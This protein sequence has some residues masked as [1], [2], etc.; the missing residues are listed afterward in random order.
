MFSR[1]REKGA[2]GKNGLRNVC[3]KTAQANITEIFMYFWLNY[4]NKNNHVE[5][6]RIP[7]AV[8]NNGH[9][10]C[11]ASK[12]FQSDE[13]H[14]FLLS[15]GTRID[16]SEYLETLINATKLVVCTEEQIYKLSIYFDAKKIA[17]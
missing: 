12:V 10:F 4:S 3:G 2:L 11:M 9:H 7:V 6:I 5:R 16:D 17:S 13:P 8:K 14:L 1:G 15:D